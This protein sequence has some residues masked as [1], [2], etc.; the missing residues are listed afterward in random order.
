MSGNTSGPA[1]TTP[2]EPANFDEKMP[3]DP[4]KTKHEEDDE[5][6]E[7][8]D[9][10]IE[11]LE[12][13]DGHQMEDD[14]EV[15]ATQERPIPEDYLKTDRNIGLTDQE[16]LTRRKKFGPNQM[17]E[18][19]ENLILKFLMFFYG[20]I[21]FVME[22][23][24][25]AASVSSASCFCSSTFLCCVVNPRTT[26]YT[27]MRHFGCAIKH[28]NLNH[29]TGSFCPRLCLPLSFPNT[30]GGAGWARG[31]RHLLVVRTGMEL[32]RASP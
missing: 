24:F 2:F 19:K 14:D 11:D 13:L 27:T 17:K 5:E 20:P 30:G 8:I 10:L 28:P 4:S 16:V 22:V 25:F 6:D 32:P 9:A 12:S 26:S 1:F 23:S 7:D 15:D 31:G 29:T 21:Q 18:E 3:E